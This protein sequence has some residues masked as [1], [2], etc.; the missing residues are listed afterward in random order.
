MYLSPIGGGQLG[1]VRE[2]YERLTALNLYT[3]EECLALGFDGAG[4][5][6]ACGPVEGNRE[7]SYLTMFSQGGMMFA[8]IN[9][10]F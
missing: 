4:G 8:L 2:M 5:G 7:G 3:P 6:G 1:S 9:C 10:K